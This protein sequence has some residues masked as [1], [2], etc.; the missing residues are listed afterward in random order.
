MDALMLRLN[1]ARVLARAFLPNIL[2]TLPFSAFAADHAYTAHLSRVDDRHFTYSVTLKKDDYLF[3]KLSSST[4]NYTLSL[5]GGSGNVVKIFL[6]PQTS[7]DEFRFVSQ[8][9][10]TYTFNYESD[11]P[12]PNNQAPS[13]EWTILDAYQTPPTPAVPKGAVSSVRIKEAINTL[14]DGVNSDEVWA[15]L[16]QQGTPL[17]EPLEGDK[18]LITFLYRGARFGVK[19]LGAPS[20]DHDPMYRL[21]N[22]DIWYR[23]YSV[24]NSTRLS[25][26][27]VPDYPRL[28]KDHPEH[29]ISLLATAQADP[30]N[31][32]RFNYTTP[33]DRYT[34]S[35]YIDLPHDGLDR[36]SLSEA[37]PQGELKRFDFRSTLLENQRRIWI[38]IPKGVNIHKNPQALNLA[39]FFD[40]L[41][42]QY[43][44]PTPAILDKLIVE[45]RIAPTIAVF[46]DNASRQ[47]RGVEL[48]PNP[49]FAKMMATELKP[50]I[51]AQ[52]N[53]T[54][55]AKHT[56]LSGSS[57]GGLASMYVAHQY[58][59]QFGKV[60]SQSGSFWWAKDREQ[61][62]WLTD[63]IKQNPKPGIAIY[64]NAGTFETGRG[65][66]GIIDS[67]QRLYQVLKAAH[68]PVQFKEYASGHDYFQWRNKIV[69]GLEQLLPPSTNL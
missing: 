41:E 3:G 36:P 54:F 42:Y 68:Y 33:S 29:R 37:S 24:P 5:K 23:S 50:W 55:D 35:S 25:Y 16:T 44:I 64:M 8:T 22:T 1:T 31:P 40:G 21:A 60:L 63:E 28:P 14:Q 15:Q 46:I 30:H 43:K 62:Q 4:H 47:S 67:N 12:Y 34:D 65:D 7:R 19:I 32:N 45:K 9:D 10:A 61:S 66:V 59:D 53:L 11:T 20:S 27:L 18:S 38:Y 52:L 39:L 58:P 69:E 26:Q 51:E 49:A 57:Y 6:T 48:P 17:V 56:L 13:I 2:L